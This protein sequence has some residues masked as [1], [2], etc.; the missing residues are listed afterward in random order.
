[1]MTV[2]PLLASSDDPRPKKRA[3]FG[4]ILALSVVVHIAL[5]LV[6]QDRLWE[7]S[8]EAESMHHTVAV[9]LIQPPPPEPPAP[10]QPKPNQKP[11]P[12]P[13]TQQAHLPRDN[14]DKN[15]LQGTDFK[16][17]VQKEPVKG[18]QDKPAPKLA[19]KESDPTRFA[20]G[21]PDRKSAQAPPVT[22]TKEGSRPKPSDTESETPKGMDQLSD[23]K[24]AGINAGSPESDIESRRIE[25]KNRFLRRML[26]Q[27]NQRFRRPLGAQSYQE[28]VIVFTIDLEGYLLSAKIQRSSGNVLL[29]ASALQAIR[30]V[31]RFDVPDS[32]MIVAR[33][34]RNLTFQYNGE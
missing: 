31:P 25:M 30:S 29:D 18:K 8:S 3:P 28:G 2:P 14:A 13:E 6:F 5:F 4:Y 21:K 26:A 32:P 10:K 15:D 19:E 27:V 33:Y 23:E 1:M 20:E 11:K 22:S 17:P 9:Q 7:P 12:K 16:A 24:L 34:Y